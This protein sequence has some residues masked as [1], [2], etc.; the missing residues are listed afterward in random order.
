MRLLPDSGIIHKWDCTRQPTIRIFCWIFSKNHMTLMISI[1]SYVLRILDNQPATLRCFSETSRNACNCNLVRSFNCYFMVHVSLRLKKNCGC[2]C[3]GV[4]TSKN[5][6]INCS[7]YVICLYTCLQQD[8][9][10]YLPYIDDVCQN[11]ACKLNHYKQQYLVADVSFNY[12]NNSQQILV[13][14]MHNS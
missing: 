6:A 8:G 4:G 1:H 9:A 3:Y 11:I 10:K 5:V 14:E 12:S 2:K 7:C 13:L